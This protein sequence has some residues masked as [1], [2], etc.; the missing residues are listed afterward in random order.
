[1]KKLGFIT[2]IVCVTAGLTMG[3]QAGTGSA[4]LTSFIQSGTVTNTSGS[5][6]NMVEVFYTLGPA[7]DN[8]ATWDS[9][10]GGGTAED[11]L[12]DN[13]Y[14]QSVRWT[15]LNISP[16]ADFNF[17]G[18]DIDV[19][20]TLDPLI[21]TGSLP[22]DMASSLRGGFILAKFSDG[23]SACAQLIEQDWDIQQDLLLANTNL[24]KCEE[25]AVAP[26]PVPSLGIFGI[27][28]MMMLFSWIG[29]R[30]LNQV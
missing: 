7:G 3:L 10:S 14:F 18:L 20:V 30:R 5:G 27:A 28:L 13:R 11:P 12:S 9:D 24:D 22:V 25:V 4:T 26:T 15:G 8:V 29:F 23:S 6:T 21:V 19:I 17:S 2:L 1:M 16:G